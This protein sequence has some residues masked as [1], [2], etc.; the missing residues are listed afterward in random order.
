MNTKQILLALVISLAATVGTARAGAI[1]SVNLGYNAVAGT[2]TPSNTNLAGVI[3]AA[4]WN[5]GPNI[6]STPLLLNN[7]LGSFSGMT[8]TSVINPGST[9]DGGHQSGGFTGANATGNNELMWGE[10]YNTNFNGLNS[11]GN[12]TA[13]PANIDLNFTSTTA[14]KGNV[15]IY[16]R[17]GDVTSSQTFSLLNGLTQV[18]SQGAYEDSTSDPNSVFVLSTGA[19]NANYVEFT[20]VTLSAS[21]FT[22]QATPGSSID[23]PWGGFDYIN[24]VE[25]VATPEPSTIW[26]MV[27]GGLVLVLWRRTKVQ[28]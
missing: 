9:A 22:V 19:N 26:L 18:A 20:N 7:S 28:S 5:N 2:V 17:A 27:G 6:G 16:Y 4:N 15:Y 25:F 8:L 14:F 1:V 24:G 21:G 10:L 13:Y 11:P 23:L 3:P 12:Y